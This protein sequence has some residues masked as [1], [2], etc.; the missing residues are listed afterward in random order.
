MLKWN[1]ISNRPKQ[2]IPILVRYLDYHERIS[3][4]VMT[5][6]IEH[7]RNGDRELWHTHNVSGYDSELD[8]HPNGFTHWI[9][10]EELYKEE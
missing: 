10:T 2:K 1:K 5:Y 8:G 9:Y 3:Y 4:V 6:E 7:N